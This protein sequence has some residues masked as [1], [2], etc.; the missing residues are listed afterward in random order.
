MFMIAGLLAA[1][2]V[3]F[4]QFIIP[5]QIPWVTAAAG[6]IVHA[7][8]DKPNI[9]GALNVNPLV[10]AL[11]CGGGIG[12]VISITLWY[13]ERLPTSFPHGDPLLDI[14]RDVVQKEIDAARAKG[15]EVE[16]L[17]PEYTTAE[18]RAEMRKEML[19]LTPPMLGAIV[20]WGLV[21]FVPAMGSAWNGACA[22]FW[23]TGLLGAIFGALVGG[24]VVWLTR[25]LGTLGFGR[26]AM[27]LGDVH[28]MFGVGAVIG[29][30]A[31]TVAFFVAPFFG[32]VLAVYL[33]ITGK[34]RELPYGPY[35]SMA[36]AFVILFSCPILAWLTPGMMG[37]RQ[38]IMDKLG[39]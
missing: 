33:L 27:G 39:I 10:A 1:S 22:Y 14:D 3:D 23:V 29:A 4:E 26:V 11:A 19:F 8:V 28:L 12:L 6:I 17:P 9:P 16:D 32:I 37:L 21:R 24:L 20:A 7:I 18:I 25:I 35:L 15:E 2:L 13:F 31:S 5:I 36:T 38:L 34:R 30:G